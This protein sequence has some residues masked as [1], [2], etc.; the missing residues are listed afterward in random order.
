MA[1]RRPT[2]FEQI[3]YVIVQLYALDLKN[4]ERI[5]LALVYKQHYN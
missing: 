1:Q 3:F 2:P 4:T 5:S